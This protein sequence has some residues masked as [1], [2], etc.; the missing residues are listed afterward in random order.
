MAALGV[1]ASMYGACLFL[2]VGSKDEM[3][4]RKVGDVH[5]QRQSEVTQQRERD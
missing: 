5:Q 3:Q 1:M 2:R 4:S